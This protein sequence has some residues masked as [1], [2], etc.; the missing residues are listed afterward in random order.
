MQVL[1]AYTAS[2]NFHDLRFDAA[3]RLFLESFR[4][5]G[6][7]QKI[8]RIINSF[9]NHFFGANPGIFRGPDAAYVL[10]YSVIMLNTDRHNTQ[11]SLSVFCVWC[12]CVCAHISVCK[13]VFVLA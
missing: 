7:A 10:A 1:D 13:C 3:I 4:L 6:E 2:F 12:V 5:P 8:D 11:V 9:G